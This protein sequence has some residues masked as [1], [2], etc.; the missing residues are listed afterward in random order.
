ME[1]IY[2]TSYTTREKRVTNTYSLLES[3]PIDTTIYDRYTT[4]ALKID[5]TTLI[6]YLYNASN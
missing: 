5:N 2:S 1:T 4:N 6:V 3:L